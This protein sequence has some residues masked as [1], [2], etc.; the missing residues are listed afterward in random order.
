M[1]G[2]SRTKG[3]VGEREVSALIRD[4]TGWDVRRRGRQHD[5]DSDL[6][7]V[8]GWSA[9]VKRHATA[10]HA[11]LRRWWGQAVEQADRD[12]AKPVLFYRV[13]RGDW[14]AVWPTAA[15]L[16][17]QHADWWTEYDWTADTTVQ[18]WVAVAREGQ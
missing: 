14:R 2:M 8:P 4:L 13:N 10:S 9:E 7:G 1:S 12:G 3:K 16:T 6:T 15:L 11:D 18:A 5:G 17:M